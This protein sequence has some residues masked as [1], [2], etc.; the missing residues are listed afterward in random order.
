MSGRVC[1]KNAMKNERKALPLQLE[2]T[3][4]NSQQTTILNS[5][6]T[7]VVSRQFSVVHEWK[8]ITK[9]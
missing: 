9:S 6:L 4:D 7:S 2:T 1:C 3:T 5:T 8:I